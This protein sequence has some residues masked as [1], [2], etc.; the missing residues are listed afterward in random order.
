MK[1]FWRKD[2]LPKPAISSED[3]HWVESN[4]EWLMM[5]L[6]NPRQEP[7][8]FLIDESSF[9]ETITKG[10]IE[11][12]TLLTD[13]C[14][15]LYIPV[16]HVQIQWISDLRESRDIPFAYEGGFES[17]LVLSSDL[18]VAPHQICLAAHLRKQESRLLFCLICE[19][20]RVRMAA[21]KGWDEAHED[22][23]AFLYLVGIYLG[24]GLLM[25]YS[26]DEV[27]SREDGFWIY[28][29]SY[30]SPMPREV[31]AYA[32]ALHAHIAKQ[33]T[34]VW[35]A[36][37]PV[38]ILK[39]FEICLAHLKKNPS[40]LKDDNYNFP[41]ENFWRL[42]VMADEQYS[43]NEFEQ[44]VNLLYQALDFMRSPEE[45]CHCYNNLGYFKLRLGLFES[46]IND[47][48]QAQK[49]DP[50][51]AYAYDN[52]GF[53][54]IQNGDPE[55]GKRYVDKAMSLEGNH[56]GYSYRNLALY[57]QALGDYP[58]ARQYFQS[59]ISLGS[60][61]ELL[62]YFYGELLILAGDKAK[63]KLCFEISAQNGEPE[64]EAALA[65]YFPSKEE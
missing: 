52:M 9:P 32:M 45:R 50:Q 5:L 14:K 51:F 6:G 60:A 27:G 47:F 57:F 39:E 40:K 16:D 19:C 41:Q 31:F 8:Q 64:G 11:P 2:P 55:T 54:Y 10:K 29:W 63:A 59:A 48:A 36:N 26:M 23:E 44:G 1:F 28:R 46:A 4:T 30:T 20:L 13:I 49:A 21:A 33:K 25:A 15:L 35:A 24:F 65:Q 38:D 7:L 22:G 61:V 18:E 37:L 17:G 12:Y 53:A 3:K 34:P 58:Q 42:V 62:H 56:D 43:K